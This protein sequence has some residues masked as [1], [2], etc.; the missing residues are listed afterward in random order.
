MEKS[1]DTLLNYQREAEER[2]RRYEEEKWKRETEL[3]EKRRRENQEHEMRM[4]GMLASKLQPRPPQFRPRQ[5]FEEEDLIYHIT[6][7]SCTNLYL[8]QTTTYHNTVNYH[9]T[10]MHNSITR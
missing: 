1:L 5:D 6:H 7:S 8:Q 9:I 2:F 4:M 3:E 10:C